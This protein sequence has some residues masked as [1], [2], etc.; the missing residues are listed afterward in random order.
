MSTQKSSSLSSLPTQSISALAD[1]L[2]LQNSSWSGPIST[3]GHSGS[4]QHRSYSLSPSDMNRSA[5]SRGLWIRG[6]G[7]KD[8]SGRTKPSFLWRSSSESSGRSTKMGSLENPE[9]LPP[10]VLSQKS[11]HLSTISYSLSQSESTPSTP[12]RSM[13]YSPTSTVDIQSSCY[14]SIEEQYYIKGG[15][16]R[17]VPYSQ[18]GRCNHLPNPENIELKIS[19]IFKE[20]PNAQTNDYHQHHPTSIKSEP[21]RITK[22]Q[23][24]PNF[25]YRE[26]AALSHQISNVRTLQ[27][28]V[29]Y[30]S[31]HFSI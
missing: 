30:R 18:R 13:E 31:G 25:L 9:D 8:K 10:E 16:S 27:G 4:A 15:I 7:N 6:N 29:G 26:E 2:E 19:R 21:A 3:R 28:H 5:L 22:L 23:G 12:S 24:E 20:S 14:P 11:R 17:H 1:G